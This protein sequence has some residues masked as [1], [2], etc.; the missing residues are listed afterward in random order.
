[1]A[2][3]ERMSFALDTDKIHLF[4]PGTGRSLRRGPGN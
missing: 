2:D 3:G 4:D 1:V